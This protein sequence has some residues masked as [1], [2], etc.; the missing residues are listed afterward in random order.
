MRKIA[1]T[2]S[3]LITSFVYMN[4]IAQSITGSNLGYNYD[5]FIR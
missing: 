4:V 1:L 2:V 3:F 5:F